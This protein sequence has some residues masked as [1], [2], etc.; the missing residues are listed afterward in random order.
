MNKF[1]FQK[2]NSPYLSIT[3]K[4][5]RGENLT[6]IFKNYNI[7][8]KD[9]IGAN[10]KLKKFINPKKLKMDMFLDLVIKK[11]ISGTTNL[12]KLN[13]PTSKSINISLDRDIN[14][15]FIA[16]KKN[17]SIIYKNVIF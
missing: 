6:N 1:I 11:N 5:T 14:D 9:I 2:V 4:I 12:I 3:H 8:E 17:Y 16:K 10:S 15:K 7:D 13:L